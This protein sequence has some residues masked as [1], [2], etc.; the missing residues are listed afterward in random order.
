MIFSAL[1]TNVIFSG[2]QIEPVKQAAI[3]V[4][5]AGGIGLIE[6]EKV[7]A[8]RFALISAEAQQAGF[9]IGEA[10]RCGGKMTA[11]RE[12]ANQA[13]PDIANPPRDPP[14]PVQK[15]AQILDAMK[16]AA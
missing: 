4:K 13:L 10:L 1:M 7:P 2:R 6:G 14:A 15:N 5:H 9:V 16:H 8:L 11:A 12:P 3:G